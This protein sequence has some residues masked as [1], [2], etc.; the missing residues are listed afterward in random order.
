MSEVWLPGVAPESAYADY[1]APPST[2]TDYC[3]TGLPWEC[4]WWGSI[5]T[6]W[7]PTQVQKCRE[8]DDLVRACN[9]GSFNRNIRSGSGAGPAPSTAAQPGVNYNDP[10]VLDRIRREQAASDKVTWFQTIDAIRGAMGGDG[11]PQDQTEFPW[12]AVLLF[13]ALFAGLVL[14]KK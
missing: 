10:A 4:T 7:D 12:L 3:A 8:A 9:A 2:L 1:V 6:F 14:I 13:V 11:N 5:A